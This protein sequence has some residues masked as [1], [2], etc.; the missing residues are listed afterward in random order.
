M[1]PPVSMATRDYHLGDRSFTVTIV[2][3]AWH[4]ETYAMYMSERGPGGRRTIKAP[5][6]KVDRW[7]S[8][9]HEFDEGDRELNVVVERYVVS[10]HTRS[11]TSDFLRE[12]FHSLDS[13]ALSKLE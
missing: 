8:T 3:P 9:E 11:E 4:T 13:Q 1:R 5:F 6:D 12:V 7:P 2:D 10:M